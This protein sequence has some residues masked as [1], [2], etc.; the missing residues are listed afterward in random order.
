V[1]SGDYA[2]QQS[3]PFLSR[4]LQTGVPTYWVSQALTVGATAY[5][6]PGTTATGVPVGHGIVAVDP[7]VIPFGTHM[8][9]PGYGEGFAADTGSA[10][11]GA[12]IDVWVPTEA[13]ASQWG[14][15]TITIYLH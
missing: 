5:A 2:L 15:K 4:A 6:L 11:V 3:S 9:I 1:P 13:E 14:V 8:T 7:N 12:R 10:I